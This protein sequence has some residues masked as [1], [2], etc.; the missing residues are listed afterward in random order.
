MTTA[1]AETLPAIA[2]DARVL[3]LG[4]HRIADLASDPWSLS[5]SPE[6]FAEQLQEVCARVRP[7]SLEH[8]LRDGPLSNPAIVVTFDDGYADTLS[9]A[10]PLLKQHGVPATVFL[11]TGCIATDREFWWDELERLL[12]T[13]GTLPS[14]LR[15]S[16]DG[17]VHDWE[18]ERHVYSDGDAA[19]H[20]EWRAWESAPTARHA[21][22]REMWA[23]LSRTPPETR[24]VILD[25][26]FAA[27]GLDRRARDTHRLLTKA[28][29]VEL[30]RDEQIQ[31]GSHT[32]S[33][34]AMSALDPDEQRAEVIASRRWLEDV[35]HGPVVTFAYPYGQKEH[36]TPQS[37]SI[38]KESGFVCACAN[39]PGVVTGSTN[40]YELPRLQVHHWGRAEF[41]RVLDHWLLR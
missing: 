3:I 23:V 5:V 21:A 31:F 33:H 38:V 15:M 22:Y 26:L 25:E 28:E 20:R 17:L 41:A 39:F 6:L 37:M 34:T 4:Y 9:T 18:F 40:A 13:P 10:L 30:A 8:V 11:P 35:R 1:D 29:T 14:R 27:T 19:S 7:Q 32:V 36:Y 12:L 16:I 2:P 24:T